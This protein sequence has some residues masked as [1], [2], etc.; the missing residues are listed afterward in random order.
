MCPCVVV[1]NVGVNALRTECGGL[2]EHLC[3][4]VCVTFFNN[5]LSI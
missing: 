1:M 2:D 3:V 5:V 4:C